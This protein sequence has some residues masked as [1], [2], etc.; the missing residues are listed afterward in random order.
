MALATRLAEEGTS[1]VPPDGL[2]FD[3]MQTVWAYGIFRLHQSS[4]DARW[5]DYNHAWMAL[6]VDAFTGKAPWS[7]HSS[8]AMSPSVIAAA[9]MATDDSADY[10]PI[11]EAADAYLATAPRTDEGAIAHWGEDNAWGFPTDQVWVDSMFMFGV[12]LLWQHQQTGDPAKLAMFRD[13]YVLFS[14]LCRDP[15]ADLY[16]HAYDDSDDANIPAEAVFWARGNSWVLIAAAEALAMIPASDPVHQEILPLFLAHAEAIAAVQAEDGLWR[17]V[18]N[19][20]ASD[21]DN[22]TETSA[23]ALIAYAL[24]RGL[25]AGVLDEKRYTPVVAAAVAGVQGRIDEKGGTLVVEGTSLGTNPGDY[26]YYVGIGQLDNL[27]LGIGA[28]TMM[29]AEVDG[30]P[31]S[32][33]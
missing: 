13:Q 31:D 25:K 1:R 2:A 6:S 12:L 28:V 22:Y 30:L 17:T 5:S 4:G 33:P 8:D 14:D 21:P 29:L 23:S 24:A 18:L 11:T 32:A 26:D 3:W 16:R 9:L 10:S 27:I 7:F 19:D 15:D 20:P